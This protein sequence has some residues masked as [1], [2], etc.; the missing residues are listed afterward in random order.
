MLDLLVEER[1][2]EK[3][4]ISFFNERHKRTQHSLIRTSGDCDLGVGIEWSAHEGA[5]GFGYGLLQSRAAL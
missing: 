3:D 1:L 2:K 4:L 5:I